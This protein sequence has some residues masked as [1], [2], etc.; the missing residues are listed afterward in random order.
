[1][2]QSFNQDKVLIAD[3]KLKE[4]RSEQKQKIQPSVDKQEQIN[5]NKDTF[6]GG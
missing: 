1:M 6:F 5:L 3:E 2:Q 4:L